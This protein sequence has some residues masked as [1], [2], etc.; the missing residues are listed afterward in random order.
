MKLKS[1]KHQN[2]AQNSMLLKK[3]GSALLFFMKKK[4]KNCASYKSFF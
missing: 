3:I 4:W 1:I 2:T